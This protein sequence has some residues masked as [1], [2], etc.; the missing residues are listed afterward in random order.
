MLYRV[1][2]GVY[3]FKYLRLLSY[4]FF[5]LENTPIVHAAR[6]HTSKPAKKCGEFVFFPCTVGWGV[7]GPPAP[8]GSWA[9]LQAPS[10]TRPLYREQALDTSDS[11]E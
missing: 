11:G 6:P 2:F 8:R 7:S 3:A 4:L 1:I 9:F 5:F 10:F